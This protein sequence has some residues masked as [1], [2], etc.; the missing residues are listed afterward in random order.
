MLQPSL[1]RNDVFTSIEFAFIEP[2]FNCIF[3]IARDS[4]RG[5]V[6][7]QVFVMGALVG[8]W[9][10]Q[11]EQER[12]WIGAQCREIIAINELLVNGPIAKDAVQA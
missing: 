1:D 6:K 8:G 11:L 2:E 3:N 12:F 10:V 7:V 5:D 4:E 9:K